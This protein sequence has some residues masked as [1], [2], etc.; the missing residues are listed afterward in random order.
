[1]VS[2]KLQGLREGLDSVEKTQRMLQPSDH[3]AAELSVCEVV[4]PP[5]LNED[6]MWTYFLS[7]CMKS[8]GRD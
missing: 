1:M 8:G 3:W 7:C 6:Y 5:L 4:W 2:E